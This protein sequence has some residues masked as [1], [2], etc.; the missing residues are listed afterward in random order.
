MVLAFDILNPQVGM[1][2]QKAP[3]PLA[4]IENMCPALVALA[5][6]ESLPQVAKINN[7]SSSD[8]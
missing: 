7:R 6:S 2:P 4:I 1:I 5:G 3:A 8:K